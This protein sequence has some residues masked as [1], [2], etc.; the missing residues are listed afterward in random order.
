MKTETLHKS[1]EGLGCVR[2]GAMREAELIS[3]VEPWARGSWEWKQ[4]R[5]KRLGK[6]RCHGESGVEMA[7]QVKQGQILERQNRFPQWAV[8]AFKV[9]S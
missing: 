3:S 4:E 8:E 5:L 7:L 2:V 9:M 1:K 6:S